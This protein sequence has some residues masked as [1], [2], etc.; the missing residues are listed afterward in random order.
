MDK[1]KSNIVWKFG[2]FKVCGDHF[3]VIEEVHQV[4]AHIIPLELPYVLIKRCQNCGERN[5]IVNVSNEELKDLVRE[6]PMAFNRDTL[7]VLRNEL[8]K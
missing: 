7:K 8:S 4:V 3:Y 5:D 6:F 1:C 2:P